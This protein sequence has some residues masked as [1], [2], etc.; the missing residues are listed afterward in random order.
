MYFIIFMSFT[1]AILGCFRN[2]VKYKML[3]ISTFMRT[4]IICLIFYLL[5]L[6]FCSYD[7]FTA[8]LMACL[9]ERWFF[10]FGKGL[11]SFINND[12]LKKKE[13]Y[14]KKYNMVYDRNNSN[15]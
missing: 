12:Y 14:I 3:S 11:I 8:I 5:I 4:P 13:K 1:T 15:K 9:F 2:Y 6:N 10:L 7:E